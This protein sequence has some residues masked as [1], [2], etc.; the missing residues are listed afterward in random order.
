MLVSHVWKVTVKLVFVKKELTAWSH[1]E[2][3]FWRRGSRCQG[4]KPWLCSNRTWF[5]VP[6]V[7][8]ISSVTWS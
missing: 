5:L 4:E 1:R 3:S 8:L 6:V 2:V 7:P